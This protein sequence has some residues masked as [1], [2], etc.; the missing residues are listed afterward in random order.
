MTFFDENKKRISQYFE[1]LASAVNLKAEQAI[2][3]HKNNEKLSSE[4]IAKREAF[5]TEIRQCEA[6]DLQALE[7]NPKKD[8]QEITNEQLF[9]NFCFLVGAQAQEKVDHFL[10][11]QQLVLLDKYLS[12]GQIKCFQAS[13]D[14][15]ESDSSEEIKDL[16]FTSKILVKY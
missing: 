4:I 14:T 6:F 9:A 8:E 2:N 15:Y 12:P 10:T 5:L 3:A 13:L 7:C 1:I 11:E 16:F